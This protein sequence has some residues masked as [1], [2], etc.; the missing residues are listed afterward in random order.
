LDPEYSIF[1]DLFPILI[2]IVF[3]LGI[4]IVSTIREYLIDLKAKEV[5]EDEAISNSGS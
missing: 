1:W 5:I 4:T 3:V 2:V